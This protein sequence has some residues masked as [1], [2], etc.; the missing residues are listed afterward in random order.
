MHRYSLSLHLWRSF[1]LKFDPSIF[2]QWEKKQLHAAFFD[3]SR[4]LILNEYICS[5]HVCGCT[6]AC[7]RVCEGANLPRCCWYGRQKIF[8]LLAFFPLDL[9][10][11]VDVYHLSWPAIH[12]PSCSSIIRKRVNLPKCESLS[13]ISFYFSVTVSLL[14]PPSLTLCL[15]L[16]PVTA[17]VR[18]GGGAESGCNGVMPSLAGGF[19]SVFGADT[20]PSLVCERHP[21]RLQIP[22][23]FH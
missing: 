20:A 13:F 23:I 16:C 4:S 2:Y 1:T 14:L 12:H 17:Q 18:H 5:V 19:R 7:A 10:S 21:G 6:W 11:N 9:F 8:F 15:T 3:T 22:L